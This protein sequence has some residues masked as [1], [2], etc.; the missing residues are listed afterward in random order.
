MPLEHSRT[1]QQA[2]PG[3]ETFA[4]RS[5]IGASFVGLTPVLLPHQ[6]KQVYKA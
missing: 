6:A 1:T 4:H 5:M 3:H 2:V